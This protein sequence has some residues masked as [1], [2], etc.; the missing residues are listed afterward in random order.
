[1]DVRKGLKHL[2]ENISSLDQPKIMF[3]ANHCNTGFDLPALISIIY[4]E[5]GIYPRI[6]GDYGRK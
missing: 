3:V 1:V 5:T 6:L 2:K 4:L